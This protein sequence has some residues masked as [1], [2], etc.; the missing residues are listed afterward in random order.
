M[1]KSAN[2]STG[3]K[4]SI[5]MVCVAVLFLFGCIYCVYEKRKRRERNVPLRP[6]EDI[7]TEYIPTEN[8]P[9][10]GSP[11]QIIIGF[12]HRIQLPIAPLPSYDDVEKDFLPSYDEID[13]LPP[14]YTVQ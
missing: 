12:N 7:P 14:V 10:E 9:T 13:R 5:A 11:T 4:L 6:T 3:L 1:L 8:T 2:W